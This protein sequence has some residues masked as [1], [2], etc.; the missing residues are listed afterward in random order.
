M[1]D[2]SVR[3]FEITWGRFGVIWGHWGLELPVR[4]LVAVVRQLVLADLEF[5]E[6]YFGVLVSPLAI[7]IVQPKQRLSKIVKMNGEY[8]TKVIPYWCYTTLTIDSVVNLPLCLA[9]RDVSLVVQH[10][11]H[12]VAYFVFDHLFG[13]DQLDLERLWYLLQSYL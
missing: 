4:L 1:I 11:H 12:R 6:Y 13:H 7:A 8:H 3:L 9:T 5:L 10:F 2:I